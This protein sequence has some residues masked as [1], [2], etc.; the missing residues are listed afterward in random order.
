MMRFVAILLLSLPA[1]ADPFRFEPVPPTSVD[2]VFLRVETIWRDSCLPRSPGVTR[3]G[4]VIE[5]T[6]R[7]PRS[8]ACLPALWP[9]NDRVPLGTFEPGQY[10]VVLRVDDILG[11]LT[12][13]TR[14]LIVSD[15]APAF[16]ITPSFASTRGGTTIRIDLSSGFCVPT[17]PLSDLTVDGIA[18][19][20]TAG[21]CSF[22][23]TL[24]PHAP[25]PVDVSIRVG[26]QMYTVRSTLRYLDPSA[27]PDPELFERIL[28]PLLYSGPGA[29]GSQWVTEAQMYN[30]AP[31]ELPWFHDVAKPCPECT[32]AVPPQAARSLSAFGNDGNGIVMFIPRAIADQV[33]FTALARDVSREQGSWGAE[34]PFAREREFRTDDVVLPFVPV[35]SRYRAMLRVYAINGVLENVGV[36]VFKDDRPITSKIVRLDGPCSAEP[37]N[38]ADPAQATVDIGSMIP[39]GTTG[40]VTV[41]IYNASSAPLRKWGFV[42]ITNND[43]QHVTVIRAQ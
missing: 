19:A 2:T 18:V 31:V 25:G 26:G 3:N 28:I 14:T 27:A 16:L 33:Q 24:P 35:D 7:T 32:L 37:C 6:W 23:A 41:R 34:V 12:L 30:G 4:N 11:I 8:V 21:P 17:P 15:G 1:F 20:G 43:T 13:A 40:P 36:A 29:F 9:W 5:V 39:E 38:S 10:S 22:T 42:S